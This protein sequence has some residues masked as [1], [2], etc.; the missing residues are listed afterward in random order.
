MS[1]HPHPPH[2]RQPIDALGDQPVDPFL[3]ER[4]IRDPASAAGGEERALVDLFAALRAPAGADELSASPGHL[5]AFDAHVA[6]RAARTSSLPPRRKTMISTLMAAKAT[7]A[8]AALATLTV[9]TAAAAFTGSLPD[10]LQDVAHHA[11]GAPASGHG[12]TATREPSARPTSRPTATATAGPSTQPGRGP[13]A[14]GDAQK[15]LCTAFL[16][17]GLATTS[18]AYR[19]LAAA[20][21]G[22]DGIDDFCAPWADG[23]TIGRPT[24]QPDGQPT[25][26]PT[27]RPTGKPTG[28]G[29]G[30]PTDA[31][32]AQP[33][34]HSTGKPTARPTA[35]PAER[36]TSTG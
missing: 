29:T 21:G 19:N 32:T 26:K 16:H 25:S 5:A 13:D 10:Q 23:A 9:G 27:A 2:G 7:V 6:T 20:A 8:A 30:S 14:T 35:G 18:T 17:G 3:V 31:P 4:L 34:G 28:Q 11:V 12:S 24:D 1:E 36:P 33:T 22:T 15:G